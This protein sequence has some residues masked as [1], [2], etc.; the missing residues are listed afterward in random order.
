LLLGGP[1]PP[2]AV[3]NVERNGLAE[4]ES[5][6]QL[7]EQGIYAS[8][9]RKIMKNGATVGIRKIAQSAKGQIY[10]DTK[11]EKAFYDNIMRYPDAREYIIPYRKGNQDTTS[12]YI[13][14]NWVDGSDLIDYING[15]QVPLTLA[16]RR[17]IAYQ[18][19]YAL[20]WLAGK[21]RIHRDIKADN[22]YRR[23]DGKILLIDFGLVTRLEFAS[24]DDVNLE[25]T[26]FLNFLTNIGLTQTA[27]LF[28][29][30]DYSSATERIT[31]F[32]D[33]MI[34]DFAPQEGGRRRRSRTTRRNKRKQRRSRKN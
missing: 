3:I 28:D 9:V 1:P 10:N 15:K 8:N 33:K 24:P 27:P 5:L 4:G 30:E 14:F 25:I 2:A 31:A 19:A 20:R 17:N 7:G 22:L 13:N 21:D 34:R 11:R 6:E 23:N 16:E 26:N 32:Y 12:V 29:I 18:T